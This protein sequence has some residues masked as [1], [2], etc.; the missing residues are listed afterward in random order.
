MQ[1]QTRD[2]AIIYV[3]VSTKEQVDEGNSLVT[4]E[5]INRE[6]LLREGFK[7]ENIF[8][9]EDRGES[10]KTASREGL[11]RL[12]KFCIQN[13]S[14]IS[15]VMF[16]KID[17]FSRQTLDYHTIR[18]SLKRLGIRLRSATENFDD[19]S[20]GQ[21]IEGIMA[22]TA[23]F[24]N[25][26]RSERCGSGMKEAV[27]EGRYVW[28]APIGY[29]NGRI[30]GK[31]NII[32][33]NMAPMIVWIFEEIAKGLS[34][35]NAIYHDALKRGLLSKSNK[36]ICRSYFY[37]IIKN[38]VYYGEIEKFNEVNQG[39]FEPLISKYLFD[40]VQSVLSGRSK[41]MT[42]YKTD[43]PDFPLRRFV[44]NDEK[45][46]ITGSWSTGRKGRKYGFYRFGTKG[47]NYT[48]STLEQAFMAFTDEYKFDQAKIEKLKSYV[49]DR[50]KTAIQDRDV[51]RKKLS[52][53]LTNLE[54]L[55]RSLI[56]KNY[57]GVI[58]DE[59]LKEELDR[60]TVEKA[61]ISA[62]IYDHEETLPKIDEVLSYAE[63]FLR[64]P[65]TFWDEA[66]IRTKL[67]L[68]WF[69]FPSGVTYSE[70]KFGT[71]EICSLFKTKDAFS[72]SSSSMVDPTGLGH[73][74]KLLRNFPFDPDSF[75]SVRFA[76][77]ETSV[78]LSRRVV[79]EIKKTASCDTAFLF[80]WTLQ[81]SNLPPPQC[82]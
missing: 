60:I 76:H 36:K 59:I 78:R 6:V 32:P 18:E 43:H 58:N 74:L 71:T 67:A 44:F 26:V 31:A 47:A 62:K 14:T 17:R 30:S 55:K 50:F 3:R 4:Q 40:K 63:K 9:F 7:P 11:Q 42:S 8:L 54:D 29:R 82:K 81:D 73:R 19:T 41:K 61:D 35:T 51:D 15:C 16:Y 13:S 39:T 28:G 38:K 56:D 10:A 27:R 21:M 46:K 49:R 66:G 48:K 22:L 52:R 80:Q 25:N 33:D 79:Q 34:D 64:S 24:D 65:G 12:L 5:R 57:K 69:Q 1:K 37:K 23:E 45:E 70:S 20:M 68:Q 53:Q 72:A 75:V 2:K 77:I